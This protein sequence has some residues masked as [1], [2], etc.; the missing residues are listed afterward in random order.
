MTTTAPRSPA[1]LVRVP[2][3]T[4][5]GAAVREAGLP[6]KGPDTV[7]VVRDAAQIQPFRT[8]GS[9]AARVL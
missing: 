4:T 2:A 5:A 6:T 7:V 9:V 8:A 1:T 3:G